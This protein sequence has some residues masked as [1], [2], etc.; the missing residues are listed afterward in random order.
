MVDQGFQMTETQQFFYFTAVI[1]TLMTLMS[2]LTQKVI[3]YHFK[4]LG[5]E[6]TQEKQ[7]GIKWLTSSVITLFTAY[8]CLLYF[9]FLR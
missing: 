5:F 1:L 3:M 2:Y 9:L 4:Q 8:F 6:L 7:K